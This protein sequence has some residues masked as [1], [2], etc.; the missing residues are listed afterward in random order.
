M[1]LFGLQT[2]IQGRDFLVE[3]KPF[4]EPNPTAV[5]VKQELSEK[6]KENKSSGSQPKPPTNENLEDNLKM[7]AGYDGV[8]RQEA[9]K[10][11][12]IEFP[13]DHEELILKESDSWP[14]LRN[15]YCEKMDTV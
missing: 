4:P 3:G 8:Q 1:F 14:L 10:L 9:S 5:K 11:W 2:L 7:I 15:I 13:G 12:R 6:A